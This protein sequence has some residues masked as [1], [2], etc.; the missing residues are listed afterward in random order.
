MKIKNI[1]YTGLLT[2]FLCITAPWSVP[3]GLVPVSLAGCS[4]FFVSLLAEKRG[5]IAVLLYVVLGAFGLPV[6]SSFTGGVQQLFGPT[7]GYIIGYIPASAFL[8]YIASKTSK[9]SIMFVLSVLCGNLIL[10]FCGT[11]WF[12]F[13]TKTEFISALTICV[14]P[15]II[16][17]IIKSMLAL[18]LS[19]KVKKDLKKF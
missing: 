2:A 18:Y 19:L 15:F 4:V 1:T 8:A 9:C 7:G 13:L 12:V 16:T 3:V 10:F 6:F 17:D 5:V 11:L 14:L